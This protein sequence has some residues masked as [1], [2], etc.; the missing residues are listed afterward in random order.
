MKKFERIRKLNDLLRS[1]QGYT[2]IDLEAILEVGER[3]I[4]KD[5]EQIQR[6]PYNAVFANIYRGKERLYRYQE[7]NF[8]LRLFEDNNDIREKLNEAINAIKQYDWTPQ[9]QWLKICLFAIENG[10]IGDMGNVMSFE[11]NANLEGV[12]HIGNLVDAITNKYPIKLTYK[13]YKA[14]E[15]RIYVHPYHLKQYNNRW[16]LIGYSEEK[17]AIH[18]YAIDRIVSIEHLS[19]KYIDTDI[20]FE[21]YFDDIIGVSVYDVQIEHIE[22]L[23]NKDRYPYIKTKPLH[24]SQTHVR[25]KDTDD[26]ICI[27]IDVKP[28]RELISLLLSFGPDIQVVSP[29]N[30]RTAIREKVA[31][32]NSIYDGRN[33]D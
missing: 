22:L 1:P 27:T 31:R 19:K 28:N 2:I 32:L 33:L 17:L 18:N 8:S 10:N 25:D 16:F 6:P 4:R 24:G 13:P 5:L 15:Q 23:V 30:L 20:D 29:D 11:N 21:D 7:I 9:Y 14:E 26:D 12:K 3:T